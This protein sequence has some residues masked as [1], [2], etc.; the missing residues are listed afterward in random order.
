MTQPIAIGTDTHS[1]TNIEN[2]RL[3][4]VMRGAWSI[5]MLV[6]LVIFAF[7]IPYFLFAPDRAFHTNHPW[8]YIFIDV[9]T[10][11]GFLLVGSFIVVRRS[12]NWMVLY[13]VWAMLFFG[14]LNCIVFTSFLNSNTQLYTFRVIGVILLY[15][16]MLVFPDG[17][18]RP[19][20]SLILIIGFIAWLIISVTIGDAWSS[21]Y[22]VVD[23]LFI[24]LAFGLS[25]YRYR[26]YFSPT[27]K[28]QTKWVIAG[29]AIAGIGVQLRT[30]LVSYLSSNAPDIYPLVH[31]IS[32]PLSHILLFLVPLSLVF[33]ALRFRLWDIDF[34]IERGLIFGGVTLFLVA[35]F[36]FDFWLAQVIF[37]A[38]FGAEQAMLAVA[39]G[40]G[41]SLMAFNPIRKRLENF[42]DQKLYGFRYNIKSVARADVKPE[43]KNPGAYTGQYCG[44]YE[45]LGVI[46]KGGMGEVYKGFGDNTVVAVKVLPQELARDPNLVKRFEREATMLARLKH[47][48]IVKLYDSGTTDRGAYYLAMEFVDGQELGQVVKE[49]KVSYETIREWLV[50]IGNALDYI[51]H[52]GLVHR[53][54]KPSN[55]ML[56]LNGDN[57]TY[58]PILM[59][60]GIAHLDYAGTQLTGTG[61]IGTIDYMAPEQIMAA[62]E[63]DYR[64]DIYSLGV[65]LFE[66]VT[67]ERLYKG[68]AGQILFAH[69]QQ[70]PTDPRDM[71]PDVPKSVSSAILRALSKKPEDRFQSASELAR[72]LG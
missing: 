45:L 55:I 6:H 68:S 66:M 30:I 38:L 8:F 12:D 34:V 31:A 69:L 49:N 53:D 59:D 65:V 60:F 41:V 64:A 23:L 37:T 72:A 52:Q 32:Y 43:I 58:T 25:F 63:V 50:Q 47:P 28:Q 15:I 40:A 20:W 62:R 21:A 10:V 14:L 48:N 46:G 1:K 51:H 42:V 54:I 61:T 4:L 16:F 11:G 67:G 17:R 44:Q 19:K 35:V 33:A 9:F 18:L 57:E 5:F 2:P 36:V 3:L 7:S 27:R 24:L 13:S 26:H 70:P 71:R 29:T 56:R 39:F 22:D